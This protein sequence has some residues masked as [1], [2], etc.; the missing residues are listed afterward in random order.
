MPPR[1]AQR[2]ADAPLVV[3]I[4]GAIVALVVVA[5]LLFSTPHATYQGNVNNGGTVS[6]GTI[7]TSCI[8]AWDNTVGNFGHPTV[9]TGQYALYNY[10]AANTSCTGVIHGRQ[11]LAILFVIVAVVLGGFAIAL[12]RRSPV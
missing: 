6:Q 5:V 7:T 8:T 10:D 2:T 11:H 4:V 12:Y 3:V 9:P 1:T